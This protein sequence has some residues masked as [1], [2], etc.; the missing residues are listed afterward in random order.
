MCRMVSYSTD[1]NFHWGTGMYSEETEHGL[2]PK[3]SRWI[4]RN[5]KDIFVTV[6][7]VVFVLWPC[8][9]FTV[10]FVSALHH[11]WAVQDVESLDVLFM[12]QPPLTYSQKQKSRKCSSTLVLNVL[13]APETTLLLHPILISNTKEGNAMRWDIAFVYR[14]YIWSRFL[15]NNWLF[16]V[17]NWTEKLL[18]RILSL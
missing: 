1:R 17:N 16:L 10:E 4:S 18:H 12:K 13:V 9:V 6:I 8:L 14:Y 5:C 15:F 2:E 3:F 7:Y 11:G